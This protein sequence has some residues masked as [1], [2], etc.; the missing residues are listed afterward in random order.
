[1]KSEKSPF[2]AGVG[3]VTGYGWGRDALWSGLHSG[4]SAVVPTLGYEEVLGHT[5]WIAS[6]AGGGSPPHGAGR[7]RPGATA[8]EA[9][10]DALARGWVPG[11][12]V[13]LVHAVVLGDVLQWRDFYLVD[14]RERSVRG[15]LSL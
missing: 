6:V 8:R 13:G 1:M 10:T 11:R 9:I 7:R 3:A 2:I 5:V 12:K 15:Y 4:V 14:G